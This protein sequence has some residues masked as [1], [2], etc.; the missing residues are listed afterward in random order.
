M[1]LLL[2]LGACS[3]LASV[4]DDGSNIRIV[5]KG[6]VVITTPAILPTAE[7]LLGAH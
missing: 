5:T 2:L 1:G 4:S 7:V 3:E 6:G